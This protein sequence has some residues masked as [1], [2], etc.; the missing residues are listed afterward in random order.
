MSFAHDACSFCPHEVALRTFP[1]Q[2]QDGFLLFWEGCPE[3]S[4]HKCPGPQHQI[5]LFLSLYLHQVKSRGV[6]GA[7]TGN[8]WGVDETSP[9]SPCLRWV[10]PQPAMQPAILGTSHKGRGTGPARRRGQKNRNNEGLEPEY[11]QLGSSSTHWKHPPRQTRYFW[12]K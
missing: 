3:A 11:M 12:S 8:V 10:R 5:S 9:P 2:H 7:L 4:T 6:M 1:G